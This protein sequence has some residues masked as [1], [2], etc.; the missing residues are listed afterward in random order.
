MRYDELK[1]NGGIK[2]MSRPSWDVYHMNKAYLASTRA[3]C[4]R[5]HVGAI[6][7]KDN[8]TIRDGYN[9]APAG[10]PD[11]YEVGCLMVDTYEPVDGV[12][13]KKKNCIRTIH[14]EQ[15]VI[16]FSSYEEREGA[17]LYVTDQPCF[18]CAKQIANSGIT[19]VVYHRPYAKDFYNV[20]ELFKAKG[21]DFIQL[22]EYSIPNFIE[23]TEVTE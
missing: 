11:C 5:R 19:K 16:I 15:N 12:V 10:I 7:V 18:N 3:T 21:I 2:R 13:T 6:L 9:G 8:K 23:K 17:T 1:R 22:Q 20:L 4:P 14:A